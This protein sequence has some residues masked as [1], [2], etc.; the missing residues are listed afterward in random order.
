MVKKWNNLHWL[1]LFPDVNQTELNITKSRKTHKQPL[2]A[3]TVKV[4]K[5]PL[6]RK[7]SLW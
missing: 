3:A 2:K 5:T 1:S 4:S 6:R 7:A